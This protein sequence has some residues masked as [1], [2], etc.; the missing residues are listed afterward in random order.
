LLDF[1]GFRFNELLVS[2]D[3]ELLVVKGYILEHPG[4]FWNILEHPG[5]FWNI[6]SPSEY[7]AWAGHVARMGR[8]ETC[9]MFWW[10]NLRE[11][12]HW[13]DPDV[14]GRIILRCIFRKWIVGV[15]TGLSWL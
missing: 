13:L 12:D 7:C 11:G 14:D 3:L 4:T 10:E 6:L 15:W 9:A 1:A 8:G 5:T 2:G